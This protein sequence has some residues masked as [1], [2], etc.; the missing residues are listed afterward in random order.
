M[1]IPFQKG[2]YRV[3]FATSPAD[4][5]ACQNLR[6]L[7]FFGAPGR[8]ADLFDQT[9]RHLM[10]DDLAGALV[11]TLRLWVHPYGAAACDGYVG[12]FYDLAWLARQKGP[13]IELGRFCVDPAVLDADAL[14]VIWGALT[15][16]VDDENV[17]LLFGC[18]SF[19][20]TDPAVYGRAFALLAAHHLGPGDQRPV[21]KVPEALAFS[22]IP[23]HG[24]R[25]MPAL[26]RSYLA[27]GGWVG[28]HL[29]VD[30]AMNTLHVFTCVDISAVPPARARAL[31]AIA[32]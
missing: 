9:C 23:D 21:P 6:H 1:T 12:Q 11:A 10:V 7:S 29:V 30:R 8:D 31:R 5:A 14:R 26:L 15:G 32:G 3:R 2:R 4:V 24:T 17:A 18:T 16:L 20:G 27:L 19:A 28:D 25:P 22:R 13:V